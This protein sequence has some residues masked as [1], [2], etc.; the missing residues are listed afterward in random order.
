MGNRVKSIHLTAEDDINPVAVTTVKF[1]NFQSPVAVL[2]RYCTNPDCDCRDTNL[3][4]HEIVDNRIKDKLFEIKIN[5]D[6]WE[7]VSYQVYRRDIESENMYR[8]FIRDIDEKT[9]LNIKKRF[10]DGKK[11]GGDTLKDRIDYD[12]IRTNEM[13]Y[14][15]E[16]F[17]SKDY[18]RLMFENKGIDYVVLDAYCT[19]PKCHC[20]EVLLAFYEIDASEETSSLLFTLL[21]KFKRGKY[22]IEDKDDRIDRKEI[23]ENYNLFMEKLNDP[24]YMLYKERYAIM[25]TLRVTLGLNT[26]ATVVNRQNIISENLDNNKV[27]RNEHCPCG[28]GK[29]YKKCCAK[30]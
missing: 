1:D 27:G 4:F 5:V 28:S 6:T 17:N 19:N 13:I 12:P 11:F 3:R 9:K 14:Y 7:T 30:Q 2:D 23:K 8:E 24:D 21:L 15:D 29:K 25:K 16:V 20:N 10:E 22:T 26:A 18:N